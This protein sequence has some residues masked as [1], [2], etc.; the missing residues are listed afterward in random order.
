VR[1]GLVV[2]ESEITV[3]RTRSGGPGGQ[4]VNKVATRIELEFD[5]GR[6]RALDDDQRARV[7]ERL[8]SRLSREGVLRVVSQRFRSQVR[9]EEDA[10]ARLA[11]LLAAALAV[12]RKRRAT[13]PTGPSRRERLAAKRRR[14]QLKG[15]RRTPRDED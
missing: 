4:N 2:P 5:V 14:A 15:S 3:R 1:P 6:T 11:A 8:G 7:R 10:R 13:R 9:N 12:P